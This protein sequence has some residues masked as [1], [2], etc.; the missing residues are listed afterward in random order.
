LL[1]YFRTHLIMITRIH[2]SATRATTKLFFMICLLKSDVVYPSIF[3]SFT[4]IN[5]RMIFSLFDVMLSILMWRSISNLTAESNW[6]KLSFGFVPRI[7][8]QSDF[9]GQILFS[10]FIL[11][12]FLTDFSLYCHCLCINLFLFS[13][14]YAWFLIPFIFDFSIFLHLIFLLLHCFHMGLVSWF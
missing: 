1:R 4:C 5:E 13:Y 6:S 14:I 12:Y 11:F 9:I 3:I 7:T 2:L 8:H 10:N